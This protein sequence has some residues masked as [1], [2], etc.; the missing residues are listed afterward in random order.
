MVA[1]SETKL[2]FAVTIPQ[3]DKTTIKEVREELLDMIEDR[4]ASRIN[5]TKVKIHLLNKETSYGK[6]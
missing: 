2:T 1:T 4:F 5:L 3:P 6:R